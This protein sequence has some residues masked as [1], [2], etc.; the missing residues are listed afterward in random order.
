MKHL[1][2]SLKQAILLTSLTHIMVIQATLAANVGAGGSGS[3]GFD[4]DVE[5]KYCTCTG[6]KESM[7]CKAMMRNCAL[8]GAA[9]KCFDIT[10]DANGDIS[11][12]PNEDG[13][14]C[15]CLMAKV[16]HT[17]PKPI[18]QPDTQ[19]I[20][21]TDPVIHDHRSPKIDSNNQAEVIAPNNRT[22][23]VRVRRTPRSS[24][25]TENSPAP[26]VTDHR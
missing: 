14:D 5:N 20:A 26:I 4:C 1:I 17:T 21:P 25:P 9:F 13:D 6:G 19:L 12:M 22:D 18:I 23:T 10:R 11:T 7:D 2:Q 16:E 8:E 3:M 24:S 15:E